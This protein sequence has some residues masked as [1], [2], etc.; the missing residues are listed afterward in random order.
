MNSAAEKEILDRTRRIETRLTAL[1]TATGVP[2]GSTKPTF[3][4][5]VRN[6]GSMS[7]HLHVESVHVS[8]QQVLDFMAESHITTANIIHHGKHLCALAL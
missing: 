2:T 7:P 5:E 1:L 4:V 8:L 6:N 3:R